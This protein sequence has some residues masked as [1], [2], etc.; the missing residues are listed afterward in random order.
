MAEDDLS[1]LT[2]DKTHGRKS[3]TGR[4]R[5]MVN[6][7]LIAMA[8]VIGFLILKKFLSPTVTVEATTV[9]LVY[10]SQSF[11]LLNASGYVAAQRKAA[12]ASK[13]TGRI[14]AMLV[15]EGN[16]I[17]KGDLI[18]RLESDDLLAAR[19]RAFA[20]LGALRADLDQA[21]SEMKD[22][23]SNHRRG[24]QLLE[25]GFISRLDYDAAETR[26]GKAAA[27]VTAAKSSIKAGEAAL[28]QAEIN[29]E[30]S[31]IRAP[32]DAV[33]LTKNADIGDIVT[34]LGAA[35]N[36]KASVVTIADLSSLQVEVDVSESSIS[37]VTIGRPCEIQLDAIPDSR[38]RGE[39]HM[40]VPT[41]DRTKATIMVKIAF[42][43]KDVRILPEMSAKVAFLERKA[44]EDELRPRIAVPQDALVM[45]NNR[46]YLYL[47]NQG[48]A[49]ETEVSSGDI[50]GDMIGITSGLKAG[51]RIVR[52]PTDRIRDN[53]KVTVSEK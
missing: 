7:A 35:A 47:I 13:V 24:R 22:A 53:V 31:F 25:Q 36:A 9:S 4:R 3:S 49:I 32:F 46:S 17:K 43:D 6:A 21:E 38:F 48:R 29:Y 15:E 27:I 44:D 12:V 40:I 51:Q 34:P 20:E 50:M 41:A 45:R 19:E 42:I 16:R 30:Y 8:V 18:A 37:Q 28:R 2:I 39:V 1:R 23:A 5:W 14:I 26:Y 52:R 11:T 10:P 33:V